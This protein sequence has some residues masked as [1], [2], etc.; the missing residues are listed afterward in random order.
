MLYDLAGIRTGIFTCRSKCSV[1]GS[2]ADRWV[3]KV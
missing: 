3:K 1:D 2:G